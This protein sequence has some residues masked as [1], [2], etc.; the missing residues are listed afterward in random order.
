MGIIKAFLTTPIIWVLLLLAVGLVWTRRAGVKRRHKAGWWLAFAGTV[1]LL[2]LSLRSV[3]GLLTWS[4]V[5][6]YTPA[7]DEV[8]QNLDLVVVLGGGMT[9]WEKPSGPFELRG[10]AYARWFHGVRAF[11][12]GSARVL[13]FCGGRPKGAAVSEA[14]VMQA[15]ALAMGVPRD[16]MLLEAKSHNT[17]QNAAELAE[18]LPPG[19]GRRI[20]L[21]TSATHMRRSESVF[22][23]IFPDD[24]VVPIP[25]YFEHGAAVGLEHVVPTARALEESTRALHEWIGMAWYALRY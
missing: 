25:V 22:H 21:V 2:V 4:L 12:I 1:L 14:E 8:L 10:E 3:A 11:K 19:A 9:G 18:R 20:G 5:R 24:T 7:G 13:A 15:M 16:G 6:E 17:M 23:T